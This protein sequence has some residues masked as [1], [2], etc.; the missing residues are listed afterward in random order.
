MTS[1]GVEDFFV[2][3]DALARSR[4]VSNSEWSGFAPAH[5]VYFLQTCCQLF[6]LLCEKSHRETTVEQ[7]L[8]LV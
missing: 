1:R 7:R 8:R 5:G 3:T 4:S 2:L 6:V